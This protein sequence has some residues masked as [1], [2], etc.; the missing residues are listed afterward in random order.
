MQFES[1]VALAVFVFK[2]VVVLPLLR[3]NMKRFC[4]CLRLGQNAPLSQRFESVFQAVLGK[5]A[6]ETGVEGVPRTH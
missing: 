2:L 3:E 6:M 5:P 4:S 1:L